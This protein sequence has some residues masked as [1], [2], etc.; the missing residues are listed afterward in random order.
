MNGVKEIN[1]DL[2]FEI[3]GGD[4]KR[5]LLTKLAGMIKFRIKTKAP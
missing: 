4:N 5:N 3:D 2:Y 1:K